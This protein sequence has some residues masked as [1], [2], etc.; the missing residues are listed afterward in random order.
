MHVNEPSTNQLL[1]FEPKEPLNYATKEALKFLPSYLPPPCIF[2]SACGALLYL[3]NPSSYRAHAPLIRRPSPS[4]TTSPPTNF[5]VRLLLFQQIA[6]NLGLACGAEYLFEKF[7]EKNF[8]S[9][10]IRGRG[11][12]MY[13]DRIRTNRSAPP[14]ELCHAGGAKEVLLSFATKVAL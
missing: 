11:D 12:P 14:V 9:L 2:G 8:L 4:P 7:A 5:V 13:K 1:I 6:G 10:I 3:R